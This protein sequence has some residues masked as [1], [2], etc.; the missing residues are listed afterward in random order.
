MPD[1]HDKV[2]S[3]FQLSV[4]KMKKVR[5]SA[6]F[7]SSSSFSRN[8]VTGELVK[9]ELPLVLSAGRRTRSGQPLSGRITVSGDGD[10]PKLA[11]HVLGPGRRIGHPCESSAP[12]LT[13]RGRTGRVA[14][15][16]NLGR[17]RWV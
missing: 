6:I 3:H 9:M 1:F 12:R 11:P 2:G 17:R 8:W 5:H 16:E 10:A 15:D 14:N 7:R 13:F 4:L